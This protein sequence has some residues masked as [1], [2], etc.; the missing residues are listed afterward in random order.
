MERKISKVSLMQL[1]FILS[2]T[3]HEKLVTAVILF[4]HTTIAPVE[5]A[6]KIFS[7]VFHCTFFIFALFSLYQIYTCS[8]ECVNICE[9]RR[10]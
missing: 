5:A 8:A 9:V 4:I 10:N 2:P 6:L 7:I 1:Q 3:T